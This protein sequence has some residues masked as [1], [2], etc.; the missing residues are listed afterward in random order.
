M[1]KITKRDMAYYLDVDVAT[2]YNRRKNK[3]NL[4]RIVMLGFKFE[5]LIKQSK[6]NYEELCEFEEK[7]K[8]DIEKY[9]KN[10]PV[11]RPTIRLISKAV[12]CYPLFL[13]SWRIKT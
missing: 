7:I 6:K 10:K 4:Y 2:L 3:P 13:A 12:L 1:G 9:P 5:D 8:E 11:F